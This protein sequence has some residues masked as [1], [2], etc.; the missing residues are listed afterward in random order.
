M[1]KSTEERNTSRILPFSC[2]GL[3]YLKSFSLNFFKFSNEVL[4]PWE[5]ICT[6]FHRNFALILLMQVNISF[7]NVWS[8]CRFVCFTKLTLQS[9]EILEGPV[10]RS[11]GCIWLLGC[12]KAGVSASVLGWKAL[13]NSTLNKKM[14]K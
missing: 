1:H 4:F 6:Q 13:Q 12:S 8:F 14:T 5:D 2:V 7:H 9:A 11:L 3:H 10:A